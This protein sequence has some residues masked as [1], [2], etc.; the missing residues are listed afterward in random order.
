MEKENS[1]IKEII[2]H[3]NTIQDKSLSD[4]IELRLQKDL[5]VSIPSIILEYIHQNNEENP[6]IFD[7]ENLKSFF[8]NF[9]EVLNI[10]ISDKKVIVLFKTF[11]I[12]NICKEF[13]ERQKHFYPGKKDSFKVRWF[14]FQKDSDLLIENLKRLFG[15]IYNQ[16]IVNIK[17]EIKDQNNMY[18]I[19]N[20]MNNN[21]GIKMNMN[22]NINNF[23]IN[24]TMNPLGQNHNMFPNMNNLGMNPMG[25]NLQQQYL[26]QLIKN[27]NNINMQNLQ[28][29]AYLMK[30]A[31][32]Q[33][34]VKNGGIN[35]LNNKQNNININTNINPNNDI[36]NNI[37][38]LNNPLLNKNLQMFAQINPQLLQNQF[39]NFNQMMNPN[40]NN[41]NMNEININNN[42]KQ[43]SQNNLNNNNYDEKGFGKYTCKY[44]ILIANDK[45]FQVARRLIGSKG[46]NMKNIVN[47]CKSSPN[48]SDKIKLRLRG[49]GSGYKEG[50]DNEESDEPLHLCISSKNPEDMKKA[51]LLVD[52]LLNKI[53]EDYKEYC[54]KN[55]VTPNNT[56]I[57]MRNESKNL[58][59][60]NNVK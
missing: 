3:Q 51:C 52:E 34:M 9:G 7:L 33:N 15:E 23:N 5:N 4:K 46:C 22:M 18:K 14:D 31:Q 57:A 49:R 6:G 45:D 30:L 10:V 1:D 54:Q 50:P 59:F 12:A 41:M 19:N 24:T 20:N 44:E 25:V 28:A 56:E 38:N 29:K 16:N 11:F 40:P 17:P 26:Q 37:N 55:N 58:G 2:S 36:N 53:H 8:N 48:E 27:N 32:A 35:I 60:N 43:N 47:S 39:K 21:I 13:L 42:I